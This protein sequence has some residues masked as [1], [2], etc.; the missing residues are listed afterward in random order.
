MNI[1]Y[2]TLTWKEPQ[3]P[4]PNAKY[5]LRNGKELDFGVTVRDLDILEALMKYRFLF[6]S[7]IGSIFYNHTKIPSKNASKRLIKMFNLGLV[8]R[9]RPFAMPGSGSN[10]FIYSLATLGY[11][12]LYSLRLRDNPDFENYQSW[13]EEKNDL[14]MSRIIHE[15]E[16]ND[17]CIAF[18]NYSREKS[19]DFDWVPTQ[20]AVQVVNQGPGK[21]NLYVRPDA[22]IWIEAE[23][24]NK[25][26]HV[27]YERYSDTRRFKEKIRAWKKYRALGA[28]KETMTVEPTI[29]IV[30]SEAD[31]EVIG[32]ARKVKSIKPF[33]EMAN[34]YGLE[35]ILF[36]F[37][38]SWK[39]GDWIACDPAGR[40]KY[41]LP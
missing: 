23:G 4:V 19:F 39:N 16:L 30:G 32:T 12:L 17:F 34:D 27:E 1:I 18:M 29:L 26:F 25:I 41:L 31:G 2:P 11:E 24:I 35:N 3:N 36:L 5:L 15:L 20:E 37:N 33:M 9:Y 40:T 6:T 22:L 7:Q 21:K 13:R 38:H 28:W 8:K 10:E 14:E